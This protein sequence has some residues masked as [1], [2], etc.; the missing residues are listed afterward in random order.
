[1]QKNKSQITGRKTAEK[2]IE[3]NSHITDQ[4]ENTNIDLL[5]PVDTAQEQTSSQ[6]FDLA[7]NDSLTGEKIPQ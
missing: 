5:E 4:T 1:M 3:I 7:D 2:K 6:N